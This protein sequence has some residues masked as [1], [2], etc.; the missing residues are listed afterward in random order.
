MFLI[1]TFIT[2]AGNFSAV[3][4]CVKIKINI[5]E[6]AWKYRSFF[7]WILVKPQLKVSKMFSECWQIEPFPIKYLE[8]A[9]RV[10]S[11][12]WRQ[13][14]IFQSPALV[15]LLRRGFPL[16][17]FRPCENWVNHHH[18]R[19]KL[20]HGFYKRGIFT[21]SEKFQHNVCSRCAPKKQGVK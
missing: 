21:D 17:N 11:V 10:G 2:F 1:H 8:S 14:N 20:P 13:T 19:E 16:Y 18:F 9:S 15:F 6:K 3:C 5:L 4:Q 7:V 12:E